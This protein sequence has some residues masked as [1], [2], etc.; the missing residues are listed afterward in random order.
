M[1][2]LRS[3]GACRWSYPGRSS[4]RN[5]ERQKME[6]GHIRFIL[7]DGIG[8]SLIDKTVTDEEMLSC[9]QEITL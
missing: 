8:K 2:G 1:F 5:K 9:I 7:M 3:S 6:Q 4:F